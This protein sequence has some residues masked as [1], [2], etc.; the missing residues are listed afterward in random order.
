[1]TYCAQCGSQVPDGAA[2]CPKCGKPA[3]SPV[4]PTTKKRSKGLF[5]VLGCGI[6]LFLVAVV[7][8][9]AALLVPN[10][11]DALQKSR[12]K[13]AMVE[14]QRIGQTVE[15]YKA[16]HE[17]APAATDM[18]GLAAALGPDYASVIPRLDPWQH[19]YRYACW[20]ESPSEKGCDHYRIASAGRDGKFEQLDLKAYEPAEFDTIQYDRDI[21]FGDGAFIVQPRRIR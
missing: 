13:R 2:F 3:A 19:P 7:G 17:Y 1:M 6:L 15:A 11:L 8:I 5:I 9:I 4:V 12:Q 20:Q 18:G 21:V 16:E 10:F 14:M